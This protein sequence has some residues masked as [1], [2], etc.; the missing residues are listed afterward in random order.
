MKKILLFVSIVF[1]V[2]FSNKTIAQTIDTVIT[3]QYIECPNGQAIIDVD[4]TQSNPVT[5]YTIVLLKLNN[6]ATS[7]Q[8]EQH[9]TNTTNIFGQFLNIFGGNYRILLVDPALNQSSYPTGLFNVLGPDVYSQEDHIIGSPANLF[10]TISND[11]LLCWYDTATTLTVNILN[12]YTPPYNISLFD[13]LMNLIQTVTSPSGFIFNNISAGDYNI[14]VTDTF[15]C[16][17]LDKPHTITVPDAL[18]PR[19]SLIVVDSISCYNADDGQITLDPIGGTPFTT[20]DPY[21]YEWYNV[22]TGII[23]NTSNPTGNVLPPGDYYAIITDANGCDTITD[24]L[25]LIN[26]D[27]LGASTTF[28]NPVCNGDN[29]GSITITIDS[30]YQGAGGQFQYTQ[31]GGA[32][33]VN[34][35]SLTPTVVTLP[36]LFFGVYTNIRVRDVDSCEYNLPA[37]TL[38][39]PPL[40]EFSISGD[41]TYNDFGVSCN[42]ICDAQITIDSVW[43]GNLPPYGNSSSKIKSIIRKFICNFNN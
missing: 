22:V 6:T 41:S 28:T 17:A 16:P 43:G 40:L 14:S 3:S 4:I 12:G 19:N 35:P 39:E 25:T 42:G 36:S 7:Y 38:T 1:L 21:L 30:V 13:N 9:I 34:F 20:G 31:N 24:T 5:N 33:W 23:G 37:D 26:P 10:Y 2:L 8:F 27:S 32:N 29:N 11:P 18:D 15:N